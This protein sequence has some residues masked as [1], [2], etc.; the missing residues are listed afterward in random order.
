[1]QVLDISKQKN[2]E[3]KCLVV[4]LGRDSVQDCLEVRV[5]VVRMSLRQLQDK[6]AQ[7]EGSLRRLRQSK[8]DLEQEMGVKQS[9][10]RIDNEHCM[11]ALRRNM[12]LPTP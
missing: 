7:A 1:M 11:G 3:K 10:L 4:Q 12:V 9:T 2:P 8:Y 5:D 6:L